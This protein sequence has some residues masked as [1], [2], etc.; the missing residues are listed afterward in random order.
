MKGGNKYMGY[1]YKIT[2]IINQK[3][4]IGLT[5]RTVEERW[6]EHLRAM[7]NYKEKRPLYSA[8]YKYGISNFTVETIEEINNE[9]LEEREKYWIAYYDTYYN[10]YNATLGG[11][12]KW[13]KN[14]EQYTKNGD[15]ITTYPNAIIAAKATGISEGSIRATCRKEYK[16]SYDFLFKYKDDPTPVQELVNNLKNNKCFK[17]VIYQY[18]LDGT[19]L[20]IYP[21]VQE[22]KIQTGITNLY[23]GVNAVTPYANYVWRTS[24]QTFYD[25]LDLTSIIVQLDNQNNIVNYFDSFLS[26]A[27][28]LGKKTGSSISEVCRLI[29]NHKSAYGYKWRYLRDVL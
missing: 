26:A 21:S 4:Y 22:A 15:Y 2:N 27:K 10:G 12:G 20:A 24:D 28:S 9:Q 5:T 14:V 29:D 23:R 18:K 7:Q 25:N 11:D 19:L 6:Q 17:K 16:Y 3:S 8:L 1:I 13:E